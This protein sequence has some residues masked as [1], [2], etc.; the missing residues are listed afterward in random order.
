MQERR[1]LGDAAVA[2]SLPY[3]AVV[4]SALGGRLLRGEGGEVGC[5]LVGGGG[6]QRGGDE[7]L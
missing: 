7:G 5:R 1:R 3:E 2:A 4:L 6:G